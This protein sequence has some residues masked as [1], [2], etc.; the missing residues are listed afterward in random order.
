MDSQST[1]TPHQV[2]KELWPEETR[3]KRPA[4][5]ATEMN[6]LRHGLDSYYTGEGKTDP[7]TIILPNRSAATA[8][9]RHE[10]RWI[11]AEPR[12]HNE[13]RTPVKLQNQFDVRFFRNLGATWSNW[14][15]Q[16]ENGESVTVWRR[17][18]GCSLLDIRSTLV[19]FPWPAPDSKEGVTTL[20]IA[21]P[22]GSVL[23]VH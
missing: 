6:R 12:E 22:A 8:D 13:D 19:R 9:G 21:C 16:N 23:A 2:I 17:N 7:A 20:S 4:D 14:S 15:G 1:L 10:K 11:V 5:V 3:T 18:T